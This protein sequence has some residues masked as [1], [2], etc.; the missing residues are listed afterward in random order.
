MFHRH[1]LSI[2]HQLMNTT[3]Y[4]QIFLIFICFHIDYPGQICTTR[5]CYTATKLQHHLCFFTQR[6]QKC[7]YLRQIPFFVKIFFLKV[8][9]EKTSTVF[10]LLYRE[11][12]FLLQSGTQRFQLQ[13]LSPDSS[14]CTFLRAGKIL[15]PQYVYFFVQFAVPDNGKKLCFIQSKLVSTGQSQK[16]RYSPFKSSA[17]IE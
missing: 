9:D 17:N 12:L 5:R 3:I 4:D 2:V 1:R 16:N 7:R 13:K 10:Q 15:D 11:V 8:A 14:C 6:L